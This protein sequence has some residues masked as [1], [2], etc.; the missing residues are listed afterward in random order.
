MGEFI[1]EGEDVG[2]RDSRGPTESSSR[3][4]LGHALTTADVS[5]VWLVP[6]PRGEKNASKMIN[7]LIFKSISFKILF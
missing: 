7:I 1:G 6:R 3:V 2:G 5:L 4:R